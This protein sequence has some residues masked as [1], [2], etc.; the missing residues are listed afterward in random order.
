[1]RRSLG[2]LIVFVFSL[3]AVP[4][5][6]AHRSGCHAAHSCP[7]DTGSYV[8]GDT[9]N[10]TYC[11]NAPAQ[12]VAAPPPAPAAPPPPA[13]AAPPAAPTGE[14]CFAETGICISGQL[15]AFWE[16][17]GAET[18]FGFPVAAGNAVTEN[19][20]QIIR[21][22][23]QRFWIDYDAAQ[24]EPY[25]YQLG[26]M[27][28]GRLLQLGRVW[29]NEPQAAPKPGCRYF[30]E[31]GRNVCAGFWSY[32]QSRGLAFDQNPQVSYQESLALFGYP[33]TEEEAYTIDGK[34]YR[35]QW[36]QRARM[37]YHPENEGTPYTIQLGL[38]N[39]EMRSQ[40]DQPAP[41][42]AAPTAAPTPQP[43][44]PTPAIQSADVLNG[45]RKQMPNGL[46]QVNEG[47]IRIA[48]TGFTYTTNINGYNDAGK[49][50]KY[51][52][53]AL[54]ME[55]TG[56]R[57]DSRDTFYANATSFTLVDLDGQVHE[58]ESALYG[59]DTYFA[60]G[61]FYPGTKANGVMVFRIPE[62]S[63]PAL[64]IYDTT[65]RVTL[66]LRLPLQ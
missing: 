65:E 34:T 7:S 21:Y 53:F 29:Q 17:N 26:I 27:G 30:A 66:D 32:W 64:L 51:V 61:T 2:L 35:V 1:M 13:P 57:Q 59:T 14:R 18:V 49:G 4:S 19:G 45:Y 48:A 12:P 40:S 39:N 37:E 54:E 52:V 31:T 5:A 20:K 58:I 6:S 55:N 24:A 36:F 41:A 9:G 11:P 28:E 10:Y 3:F 63:G 38:L 44:T 43:T 22:P 42:P 62:G 15:R 50:F 25:T 8:C 16:R 46:W 23:F 33:L 47:G 60:G 56:Y